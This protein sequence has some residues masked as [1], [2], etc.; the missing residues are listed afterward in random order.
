MSPANLTAHVHISL[1]TLL[2]TS[3]CLL[4]AFYL[5]NYS[6][7]LLSVSV[8]TAWAN[9]LG[10]DTLWGFT[11]SR[12]R[13]DA[14][15]QW[16]QAPWS[17]RRGHPRRPP[18]DLSQLS[19]VRSADSSGC[20]VSVNQCLLMGTHIYIYMHVSMKTML[21]TSAHVLTTYPTPPVFAAP[22]TVGNFVIFRRGRVALLKES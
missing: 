7:F 15:R 11:A 13:Q 19:C 22:A 12:S 3:V 14:S 1:F 17:Y 10:R 21:D 20:D 8:A 18:L 16:R 6:L 4:I 9:G 5:F 2:I